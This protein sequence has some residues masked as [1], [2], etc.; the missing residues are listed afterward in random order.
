LTVPDAEEKI[1]E[2]VQS[3]IDKDVI[4]NQLQDFLDNEATER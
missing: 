3:A 1:A 4:R 2:H